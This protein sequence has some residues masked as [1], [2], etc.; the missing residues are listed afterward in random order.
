ML[1]REN[2]FFKVAQSAMGDKGD[3]CGNSKENSGGRVKELEEILGK[4]TKELYELTVKLGCV[5]E[6]NS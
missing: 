6:E 5:Q 4:K 1:V 3:R 2:D